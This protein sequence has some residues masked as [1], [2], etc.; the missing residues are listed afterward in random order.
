[1]RVA[2]AYSPS[3]TA[4]SIAGYVVGKL[5]TRL[6]L[7]L[8]CEE[9]TQIQRAWSKVR[10]SGLLPTMRAVYN[11]RQTAAMYYRSTQLTLYSEPDC[12]RALEQFIGTH[13]D[14]IRRLYDLSSAENIGY[15]KRRQ[16]D[17][18]LLIDAGG[19]VRRP[20]IDAVR[21]GIINAHGGGRLPEYRGSDSLEWSI[22][23]ADRPWINTHFVDSG[24]D[25]GPILCQEPMPIRASDSLAELFQ[26]RD[27]GRAEL[28]AD[29]VWGLCQGFVKPQPQDTT[30]GKVYFRMHPRLRALLPSKLELLKRK[31][32]G[33][34]EAPISS[35][36]NSGLIDR[37]A[38]SF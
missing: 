38:H 36:R 21:L 31:L 11:Q 37:S 34:L 22:W 16:I 20:L 17:L 25:T 4:R 19:V 8:L 1:M 18:L 26:L 7:Y 30:R 27:R 14:R 3:S 32:A 9:P 24:I 35:S 33:S 23:E 6:E 5:R 15:L 2:L 10:R 29:T 12:E 28:M 13:P